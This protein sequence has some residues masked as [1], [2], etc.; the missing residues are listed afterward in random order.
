MIKAG[1][2]IRNSVVG[3]RTLVDEN[4]VIEDTLILGTDYYETKEVRGFEYRVD[5]CLPVIA[6]R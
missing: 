6:W 4:A 5:L 3:L 1:A 2:V